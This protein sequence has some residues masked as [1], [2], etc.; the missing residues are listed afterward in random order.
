VPSSDETKNSGRRTAL[1]RWLTSRDQPLTTRVLMNWVWQQHFG[2]GLSRSPGDF[3]VMGHSPSHPELL[4]WL[5]T[6]LMARRW[7]LKQMHK[8]IVTS[9]AY[10]QASR[11]ESPEWNA[12]TASAAVADFER[13]VKADPENK[14]LARANRR[15]L[16]G[17]AIRDA[18]LASADRLNR[19]TGGPGVMVPLPKELLGTLLKGQWKEDPDVDQHRRRSVYLFVRRNLRYPL[20]EAFDRP[21]TNASC[22]RRN[23]S[24]TAPQALASYIAR[25]G[26]DDP[27]A[28]IKLLYQRTLGRLPSDG[29]LAAAEKFLALSPA[30]AGTTS[31]P[32]R[33][34]APLP[35]T[36]EAAEQ[37]S[38]GEDVNST[39]LVRLCLAMF[40]LNEFVYVD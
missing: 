17:E 37:E 35:D 26:G 11:P 30:P 16:D 38:R 7:S 15:R 23:V 32:P 34:V 36:K 1:A 2:Q 21:D 4:D 25:Q 29:E 31:T 6:E 18:M 3:G 12:A 9:A 19:E 24:T 13:A 27:A 22:P 5:A 39:A 14:L 10:R 8:L 40:N 33:T 28:R 20:F